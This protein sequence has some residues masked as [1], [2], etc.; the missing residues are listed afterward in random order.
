[1]ASPTTL[2]TPVADQQTGALAD[3]SAAWAAVN[4]LTSQ[5][6][7]DGTGSPEGVVTAPVGTI[8]R[9]TAATNGAI[10]WIKASG[11]GN[12]GWRVAYGDTGVRDVSAG[13]TFDF[14]LDSV[15]GTCHLR[16]INE[17]VTADLRLKIKSGSVSGTLNVYKKIIALPSGFRH[18]TYTALGAAYVQAVVGTISGESDVTEIGARVYSGSANW[19]SGA[20]VNA[21][22]S[23]TTR[24]AWPTSL[25]GSAV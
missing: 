23:W 10:L 15:A 25:P 14:D 18:Y 22:A 24:D 3:I 13:L 12:T 20:Q 2:P 6:G 4:A 16:R 7:R 17:R 19:A 5:V 21:Q 8:Y 11:S 1:M 9:D